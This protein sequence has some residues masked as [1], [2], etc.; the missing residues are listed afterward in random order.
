LK[1]LDRLM[2]QAL[3]AVGRDTRPA[4]RAPTYGEGRTR[5]LKAALRANPV[6]Q[7]RVADGPEGVPARQAQE[8][9]SITY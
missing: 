4:R 3:R 7:E 2:A 6:S 9:T 1:Q 5:A 8:A